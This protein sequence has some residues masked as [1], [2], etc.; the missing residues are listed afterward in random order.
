MHALYGLY[1][2]YEQI[3][4]NYLYLYVFFVTIFA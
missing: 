1:A 2:L 4:L 3:Q